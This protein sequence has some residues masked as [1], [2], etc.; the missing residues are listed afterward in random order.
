MKTDQPEWTEPPAKVWIVPNCPMTP[1]K[2]LH[3]AVRIFISETNSALN[4]QKLHFCL[5][6]CEKHLSLAVWAHS[7]VMSKYKLYMYTSKINAGEGITLLVPW[8]CYL[9]PREELLPNV[10][11]MVMCI[12]P[13]AGTC[14]ATWCRMRNA[15]QSTSHW[16]LHHQL[17]QIFILITCLLNCFCIL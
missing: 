8:T 16:L 3:L 9:S 14:E 15:V 17:M 6:S 13:S 1:C 2:S 5:K 11:Y 12:L 10:E 7:I 4:G